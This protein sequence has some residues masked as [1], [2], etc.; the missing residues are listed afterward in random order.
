[1]MDRIR[2][3][4][5]A[6]CFSA[7]APA[8]E[9]LKVFISVD[10]EGVTGV[11]EWDEVW[12]G[13]TDYPYFREIMTREANAA[14]EGAIAAGATEIVVRDTHGGM[15]HLLP[16][17]L[18]RRARLVRGP[19]HPQSMMVTMEGFD[20][21]FDAVVLIGFHAR[22]GFPNAVLPHTMSGNVLDFKVNGVS[23]SEASYSALIAGL[24]DVPVVMISGD[25]AACDDARQ[26]LGEL[27][28]VAVKEG[29]SG[30]AISLHPEVAREQIRKAVEKGVRNRSQYPPYRLPAPYTMTLKLKEDRPLIKGAFKSDSGDIIFKS[31]DLL[32]TLHALVWMW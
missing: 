3:A 15:K 23:Q 2:L 13:K 5:A 6:L 28:T 18:D 14:I 31:D 25:Q 11:F 27:E 20:R 29:I 24:H 22:A 10:M 8:A 26:V 16:E 9:D 21:S 30:A 19:T 1:M 4:I 7:A 17:L 32:E 12:H